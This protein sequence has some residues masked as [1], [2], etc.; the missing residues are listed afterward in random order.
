MPTTYSSAPTK[1]TPYKS[2]TYAAGSVPASYDIALYSGAS[3]A[4]VAD[5]KLA[6]K[7]RMKLRQKPPTWL[8]FTLDSDDKPFW[9]SAW[10]SP[11]WQQFL[12]AAATQAD[13]WNNKFW[14]VAPRTTNFISGYDIVVKERP[15]Q[16][17]R[18]NIR[19]SLDVDFNPTDA[20]AHRI[21]DVANLNLALLAG[22]SPGPGTFRSHS[23]LWDSLDGI[24]WVAPLGTGPQQPAVHPVI[25]HE[26][27]HLIGL[28]HIGTILATPLC[29]MAQ[30]LHKIGWDSGNF[31]GGRNSL[32]CYGVNQ[33]L[34]LSGNIMG[35]GDAFTD[36]NARPWLW[37]IASM[38]PDTV[39]WGWQA[40]TRDPGA[41][42]WIRL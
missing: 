35:A 12:G 25:A 1:T 34:A 39:A 6:I 32:A 40:V 33:G 20:T 31:Q 23:L 27:G 22:Q 28:G 9:T 30:T 7:L 13:L 15:N 17:F 16:A 29:E 4:S 2:V 36:A 21:I 14:L 26:I 19:C 42:S 37:S 11:A 10:T 18:P 3:T 8:P 38:Y 5:Y 24:P 41:G